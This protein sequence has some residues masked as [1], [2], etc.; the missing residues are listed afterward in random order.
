[1]ALSEQ[2]KHQFF[3]MISQGIMQYLLPSL[4]QV[5]Q[6]V[7]QQSAATAQ[8]SMPNPWTVP[9]VVQR[10]ADEDSPN[11]F[12][13]VQVT[14]VQLLAEVADLLIDLNQNIDELGKIKPKRRRRKS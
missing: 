6:Q 5:S 3:S 13:N 1:M 4:Q 2:E 14:P 12:D 8:R 11:D 9:V 7:I 10:T